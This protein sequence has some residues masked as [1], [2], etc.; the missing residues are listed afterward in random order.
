MKTSIATVSISGNFAEKLEAIAA[1]GFH[2]L[3]IFEQDFIAHD[4]NP[5]EVGE[6]IRAM[7]LEIT[8]FQPFRDFEGLPD[9]LRAKAF[10]RAEHKF[11]LIQELGTDLMLICSS[12]HPE[13][14]GGIDRAAADFHELG[15]AREKEGAARRL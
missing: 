7:G 10:D 4:A 15:E 8:I 14:I 6:M 9:P 3:E 5:R 12:C 2:G 11:D 13:A 1:A